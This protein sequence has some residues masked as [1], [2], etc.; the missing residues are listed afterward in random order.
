[1][2]DYESLSHTKWDCKYLVVFIP[3]YRRKVLYLETATSGNAGRRR[4]G[5]STSRFPTV[6][7]TTGATTPSAGED[8]VRASPSHATARTIHQTG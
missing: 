5:V 6:L 3:K 4:V 7:G 8:W 2:D 1:V